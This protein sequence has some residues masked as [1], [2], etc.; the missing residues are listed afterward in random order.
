MQIGQNNESSVL[1]DAPYWCTNLRSTVEQSLD[2]ASLSHAATSVDYPASA[3]SAVIPY[4]YS[5]DAY[6]GAASGFSDASPAFLSLVGPGIEAPD[7]L[8]M[9]THSFPI[10]Q[11]L[12]QQ[13]VFVQDV[14]PA[15]TFGQSF[16]EAAHRASSTCSSGQA[17][18]ATYSTVVLP[19]GHAEAKMFVDTNHGAVDDTYMDRLEHGLLDSP[20]LGASITN[21]D[22]E[23]SAS[24]TAG[25]LFRY[26]TPHFSDY[27][28]KYTD[29]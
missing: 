14:G 4:A 13:T 22:L 16:A 29:V 26:Q 20:T 3:A 8:A 2:E 19:S 11:A 18:H 23:Q 7:S 27:A 15:A 1:R 12:S 25:E 5:V 28:R 24:H 6:N 10:T 21:A 17:Q 9:N